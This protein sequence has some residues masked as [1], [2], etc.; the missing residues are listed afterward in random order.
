MRKAN[1]IGNCLL[2]NESGREVSESERSTLGR[3]ISVHDCWSELASRTHTHCLCNCPIFVT[4]FSIFVF[5]CNRITFLRIEWAW[6]ARAHHAHSILRKV[7]LQ[8][9]AKIPSISLIYNYLVLRINFCSTEAMTA[10]KSLEAYNTFISGWVHKVKAVGV[11]ENIIVIVKVSEMIF[12]SAF[13]ILATCTICREER[14]HYNYKM[15][16]WLLTTS[17]LWTSPIFQVTHSMKIS[18]ADLNPWIIFEKSS[19]IV[20]SHCNWM[21]AWVNLVPM[22]Q[23][24]FFFVNTPQEDVLTPSL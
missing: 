10:Y 23:L 7:I 16:H 8:F 1:R 19:Q 18:E 20:A 2:L 17:A 12:I 9:K 4:W 14:F 6:W 21:A 15:C 5:E 11:H 13:L 22:L 24:Y 3:S